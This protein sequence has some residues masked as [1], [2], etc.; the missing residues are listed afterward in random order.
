MSG[1][2]VAPAA[3]RLGPVLV[4]IAVPRVCGIVPGLA[5]LLGFGS[6]EAGL[7]CVVVGVSPFCSVASPTGCCCCCA[8]GGWSW[9]A[10]GTAC[11]AT[12]AAKANLAIRMAGAG[13]IG[14]LHGMIG[15]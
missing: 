6:V 2:A 15:T 1:A 11:G 3:A 12:A 5:A 4:S 10:D 14:L 9:L 7:A 8:W 13:T